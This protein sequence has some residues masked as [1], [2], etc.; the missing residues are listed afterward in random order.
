MKKI[1][2]NWKNMFVVLIMIANILSIFFKPIIVKSE[3]LEIG[4]Q[5]FTNGGFRH[6][7]SNSDVYSN[8]LFLREVGSRDTGSNSIIGYCFNGYKTMPPEITV[9][10]S[11]FDSV[12][13]NTKYYKNSNL[14]N[15]YDYADNPSLS[16]EEFNKKIKQ[17]L[18]NGYPFDGSGFNNGSIRLSAFR[19]ATQTAIWAYTDGGNT[20]T[21]DDIVNKYSSSQDEKNVL[22]KLLE[23]TNEVPDNFVLDFYKADTEGMQNVISGRIDNN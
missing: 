13:V 7:S 17:I 5:A 9:L 15:I 3:G 22:R 16:R 20:L 12:I 1:V 2:R 21:I 8:A 18:Y 19:R 23:A 11:G 6:S 14:S 4:Y 10:E